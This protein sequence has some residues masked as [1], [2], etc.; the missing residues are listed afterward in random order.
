MRGFI[1]DNGGTSNISHHS[2]YFTMHHS[3]IHPHFE[4]YFCTESFEQKSVINGVEYV[5]DH[6]CVIISS[7]FTIHSMSCNDKDAK[8]CDRFIFYFDE[9]L[10]D[11]FASY[12]FDAEF[13]C[14]NSGLMFKLD[15]K[16]AD[17]LK[18]M[19]EFL[20]PS[21]KS[22][23]EL[24]IVMF[25]NKLIGFCSIDKAIK[26]GTSSFYIQDVLQYI[27]EKSSEQVSTEEIAKRFAISRSKLYRDFKR[28]TGDTM[29]AYI[30]GCKI[31]HAKSLLLLKQEYSVAEI[32]K[33]CGF[34][35]ETY[36][37]PF[38]RSGG[39]STGRSTLKSSRGFLRSSAR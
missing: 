34:Q 27:A 10:F 23:I 7:P 21:T 33:L 28:H 1:E 30:D 37:F 32:T 19:L 36:F 2:N 13:R 6:P 4:V 3:H 11:S 22:E 31:N 25:L 14:K 24:T 12:L 20:S 29:N 9:K 16:Q 39:S 15:K 5:Y 18:A 35:N 17:S 26:V 38:F 8:S